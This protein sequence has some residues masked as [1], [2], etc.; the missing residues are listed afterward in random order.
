MRQGWRM[1]LVT[2]AVALALLLGLWAAP[3][4]TQAKR[5]GL[6]TFAVYQGPETLNPFIAT[7]T[8]SSEGTVFI[9]EGLVGGSPEGE[10][11]P[12]LATE[13]PARLNGGVGGRR[14]TNT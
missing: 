11:F 4:F 5:G 7:Q 3:A 8:A 1:T 12:Q 14:E 6:I 13:N 2:G 10:D 9:V